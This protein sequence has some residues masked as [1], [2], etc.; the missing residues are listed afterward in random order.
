MAQIHLDYQHSTPTILLC[1][2]ILAVTMQLFHA[3]VLFCSA[4][5]IV[6]AAGGA[7]SS[8]TPST[9]SAASE[10]EH[11]DGP[12]TLELRHNIE[13]DKIAMFLRAHIEDEWKLPDGEVSNHHRIMLEARQ[14]RKNL[15]YNR[16]LRR[17]LYLD[18]TFPNLPDMMLA[19][20]L[21]GHPQADGTLV[22]ALFTVHQPY[23]RDVDRGHVVSHGY[24]TVSPGE[25]ALQ[26]LVKQRGPKNGILKPGHVLTIEEVFD[27]LAALKGAH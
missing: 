22:W 18:H 6:W 26:K 19:T 21:H 13:H 11:F 8:E 16:S 17:F 2:F 10:V 5:S 12:Y 20:P 7:S 3:F 24:V 27:H 15:D 25:K 4:F 23:L 1:A 14:L 9:S